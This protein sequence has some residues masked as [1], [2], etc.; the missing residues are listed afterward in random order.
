[1][2]AGAE[3]HTKGSSPK[4]LTELPQEHLRLFIS[5]VAELLTVSESLMASDSLQPR[6]RPHLWA[7]RSAYQTA[8]QAVLLLHQEQEA[9]PDLL[10]DSRRMLLCRLCGK[11]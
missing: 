2:K 8:V 11:A 4:L 5:M 10:A 1:M 3:L 7:P 6:V 9:P